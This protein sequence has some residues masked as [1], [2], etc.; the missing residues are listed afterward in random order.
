MARR[1]KQITP[2]QL[3]LPGALHLKLMQ[4][5]YANQCSL[6]SEIIRRLEH[7]IAVESPLSADAQ[8]ILDQVEK[9]MD[10]I[11]LVLEIM[12]KSQA[13]ERYWRKSTEGEDKS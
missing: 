5:A 10:Q 3:R 12:R 9:R 8:R 4:L 7:S 1:V 13:G 11:E 6:H 2:F